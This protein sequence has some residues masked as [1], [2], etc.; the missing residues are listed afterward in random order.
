MSAFVRAEKREIGW[1]DVYGSGPV[2][3]SGGRTKALQLAAVY[4]A[5]SL[6]ADMFACLPQHVYES[7]PTTRRRIATPDWMLRPAPG[8]SPIEWRYQYS[9]SLQLRGN[10]YGYVVSN[11]ARVLG[12]AWLHPDSVEPIK[13]GDGPRY[14]I[15][16]E[17]ELERP[18]SQ[19]GRIIHVREFIEPGS[20]KGL[21]PI[22]QFARDFELGHYAAE[23][24]RRY[25]E[26]GATP[27]ALLALKQGKLDEAQAREAKRLFLESVQDGGLVT[28]PGEWD[29][30][31]LSI[32][33]AEAQ[34]LATIKANATIIGVI[35]RVPPE[36]IGGEAA[37]SR[38]Y[39]NREADAERFNVRKMLPHVARYEGAMNELLPDG[40]FVKLAMDAL[41]RPNL[42]DRTRNT[43]EQLHNGTLTLPE[44]RALEDR[45]PL[46]DQQIEE[47]QQW[48]STTKSESESLAESI[49]TAITKEAV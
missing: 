14:R 28:L 29:Y 21:S 30:K 47:W 27:T 31:K 24:G 15:S 11:G 44:A 2:R 20:I 35:F 40:Q 12:V 37:S 23:F 42:L 5:V 36:D 49:S 32:D 17:A 25:F 1:E 48:Y 19:G 22:R 38:T 7:T 46:T 6:I 3:F 26:S 34:F 18:Y 43:T 8:L 4:A 10:A 41:T 16:G 45:A 13:T 33:P 39:G 9:T